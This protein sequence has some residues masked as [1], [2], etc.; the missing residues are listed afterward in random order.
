MPS[1][2]AA[3]IP[4][5]KVHPFE[6]KEAPYPEVF[7]DT[8]IIKAGAVA[9]N[10]V[11]YMIQTSDMMHTKYPAVLGED[12]AG[13]IVE[14]G[15]GRFKKGDRVLASVFPFPLPFCHLD[16]CPLI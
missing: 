11:D 2:T 1:N 8:V 4:A 7:P 10:P 15:E 13:E 14:G 3:W 9:M 6:V 12:V 5:S 16:I